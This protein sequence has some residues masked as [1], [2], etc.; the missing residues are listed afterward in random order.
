MIFDYIIIIIKSEND[1][2]NRVK[3]ASFIEVFTDPLVASYIIHLDTLVCDSLDVTFGIKM[4][5][6]I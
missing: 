1:T 3:K 5:C 2:I 4:I 6:I